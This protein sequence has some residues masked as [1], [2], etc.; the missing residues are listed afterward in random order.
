M[1]LGEDSYSAH[2]KT[3]FLS[4]LFCYK[5]TLDG[6]IDLALKLSGC[7]ILQLKSILDS[8]EFWKFFENSRAR[9]ALKIS[10]EINVQKL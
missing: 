2:E 1:C 10:P 6:P 9:E 5:E 3:A 8:P 4:T 7:W